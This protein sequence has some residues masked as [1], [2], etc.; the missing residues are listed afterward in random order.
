MNCCA[1]DRNAVLF[2]FD[3]LELDGR[4]L[5]HVPIEE[6]KYQLARLL[7]ECAAGVQLCSHL[8]GPGDVVFEYA[9]KLGCEG[10]V[11]KRVGSK[12]RPGPGKCS[13]WIK[14]KNPAAPAVKR[15]A[16]EDW[17]KRRKGLSR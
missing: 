12:Y 9:C 6:R 16:E 3:L 11:S 2:A 1:T 13:D 4:E 10:I 15:E 5:I 8:E 7:H 14:V 17:G